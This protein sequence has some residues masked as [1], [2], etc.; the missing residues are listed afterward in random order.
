MSGTAVTGAQ[1]KTLK[2]LVSVE[3]LA[4]EI[5]SDREQMILLQKRSHENREALRGIAK[6]GQWNCWVTVGPAM[7]EQDLEVTKVLIE[8]DQKQI[9]I[10]INKLRSDLRVK[11]NSLRDLEMQPPV[12]G[13]M[14]IP[15]SQK[16]TQSLS[17]AGLF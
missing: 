9:N 13:L 12:P 14:L 7:I 2:Y 6:S 10:D 1:A 11:V 3:K 17:S 16:E 15:M 5:L 4:D 8:A